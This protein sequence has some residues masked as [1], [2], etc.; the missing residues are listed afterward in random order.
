MSNLGD[1]FNDGN[2]ATGI[3]ANQF[4]KIKETKYGDGTYIEFYN[5]KTGESRLEKKD[6]VNQIRVLNNGEV[7][8][9]GKNDS[10]I[11][12][13][14][15]EVISD[16]K[17]NIKNAHEKSGGT[18]NESVLP[19]WAQ[20]IKK[21]QDEY[22]ITASDMMSGKLTVIRDTT[23][24]DDLE[25]IHTEEALT[26]F[27][28]SSGKYEKV[29]VDGGTVLKEKGAVEE[30]V[31]DEEE[32]ADV[33]NPE[34]FKGIQRSDRVLQ[35]LNLRNLKY[36]I[37]ADYGNTQDYIQINQFTYKAV[38][39]EVL[40]APAAEDGGTDFSD[41]LG[42]LDFDDPDSFQQGALPGRGGITPLNSL[43]L[44][45]RQAKST[46]LNGLSMQSPKEEHIGLVKLPMP[47][48]LSDSN[49][50]AWGE[51]Q[52]NAITAAAATIAAG[53][54]DTGINFLQDI[55]SGN[56]GFGE[57]FSNILTGTG[58]SF[59]GI[60]Q[61]LKDAQK[62]PNANLLA[63]ST[64]GSSLLNLVGFGVSPEAILARGA[65]VV[66][67][68]NLQLL[69]NAPTLRAFRFDWKMSPRSREEAIRINNIIR[70]FKQGMAA[71]KMQANSGGG[72]YFL[73]TP[74]VF[75]VTFR[76]SKLKRELGNE[77]ISVMRMKTCACVGA[78]VNY[79]P[80]GM[81]NAYEKGQPTSCILSLQFK[82]LEPLFNTDYEEDPFVYSNMGDFVP[83]DSVGY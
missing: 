29:E 24:F 35:K 73:G 45:G 19:G 70:F 71:K 13:R 80:E 54:L 28:E 62:S 47:N 66:P 43:Q 65:G 42:G 37:D 14:L 79:T 18:S 31:D 50:V 59:Q 34:N 10:N 11:N 40:F 77:N 3:D 7:T 82:E 30:I 5:S 23:T 68:S 63:R 17:R 49:N 32:K 48:Q 2:T 21:R 27:L 60:I 20:D 12:Q 9:L 56:K 36:P 22:G 55:A 52:L 64:V 53:G 44:S 4:K 25:D 75:D 78:A 57:A 51:D 83:T 61:F 69:F 72:A 58:D 76:T 39:P 67:N 16:S 33:F 15:E 41:A 38:N 6:L 26:E 74:N 8:E 81:G 1:L 46:L